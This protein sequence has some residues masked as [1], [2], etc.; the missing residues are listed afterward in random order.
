MKDSLL[1]I[2]D[3]LKRLKSQGLDRVF[4]SDE[5]LAALHQLTKVSESTVP[6]KKHEKRSLEQDVNLAGKHESPKGKGIGIYEEFQKNTVASGKQTVASRTV[7]K[8]KEEETK[9]REFMAHITENKVSDG[10]LSLNAETVSGDAGETDLTDTMPVLNELKIKGR[11]K[12]ERINSLRDIVMNCAVC[13]KNTPKGK[14]IVFGTGS[15]D[16]DIFFCGEAPGA[17]EEIQGF[18]FVGPAGQLLTKM[19]AAMGLAREAVYISNI[20][21]Y[22]PKT[23]T[24]FGNRPPTTEEMKYC[25]PYLIKQVEII[26]PKVIVALGKTATV[27]LLGLDSNVRLGAYRGHWH[28]FQ[29]IPLRVTYH[30]SFLLQHG[31]VRSKREAW[32]DLLEVMSFLKMPISEKQ[33]NYFK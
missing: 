28:E 25:L 33:Q 4:V 14:K 31:S 17:E 11:T 6:V 19:I 12:E 15:L 8:K 20:M 22:R 18:P 29:G 24:G 5:T 23:D 13:Q 10:V 27:G 30:P 9:P 1:C 7:A 32:E 21:N 3:E 26:Q 16:A 2:I